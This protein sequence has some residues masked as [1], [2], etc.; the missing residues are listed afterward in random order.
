MHQRDRRACVL[1]PGQE[2]RKA[3]HSFLSTGHT[4]GSRVGIQKVKKEGGPRFSSLRELSTS[5]PFLPPESR[6]EERRKTTA[7][8]LHPYS[9]T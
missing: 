2:S 3:F 1:W 7:Q 5:C 8:E 9:L 4:Y 6:I